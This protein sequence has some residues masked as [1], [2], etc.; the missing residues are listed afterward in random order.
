MQPA[1][2][3]F[4]D[5]RRQYESLQPEM[6]SAILRA[7]GRG[8]FILGEDTLAF[9]KEFADLLEVAQCIGVGDGTDALPL[10]LRGLGIGAGHEAIL[11][12][13]TFIATAL[14]VSNAG[15]TPV[16]VDCEPQY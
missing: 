12:V 11:P 3:Q 4:V 2:I 6:D 13:N 7:V 5:L 8:D 10:A 9:E 16:L 14:A 1:R 15:A